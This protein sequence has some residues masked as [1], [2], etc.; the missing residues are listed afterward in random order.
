MIFLPFSMCDVH[1]VLASQHRPMILRSGLRYTRS[2]NTERSVPF[3]RVEQRKVTAARTSSILG[4]A[5]TSKFEGVTVASEEFFRDEGFNRG[6]G[7]LQDGFGPLLTG[8]GR[9]QASR[10]GPF[11][12]RPSHCVTAL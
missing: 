1:P 4:K 9:V 8:V 12:V 2:S 7:D 5:T 3:F 6:W 11:Q 10:T